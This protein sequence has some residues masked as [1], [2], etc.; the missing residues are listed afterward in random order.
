MACT[1]KDGQPVMKKHWDVTPDDA[2]TMMEQ[3]VW[4]PANREYFRGGGYSVHYVTRGGSSRHH[5]APEHR[6][7][8]RP[9]PHRG[10]R[11]VC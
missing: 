11:L 10:G 9:R 4:C 5:D 1:G 2:K 3:A 6:Q 8:T 7:G